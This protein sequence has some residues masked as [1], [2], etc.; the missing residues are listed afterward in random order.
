MLHRRR[1]SDRLPLLLVVTLSSALIAWLGFGVRGATIAAATD[2]P[3]AARLEPFVDSGLL[4]APRDID[5]WSS[6]VRALAARALV[7]HHDAERADVDDHVQPL[8]S[9]LGEAQSVRVAWERASSIP[10]FDGEV[11]GGTPHGDWCIWRKDGTRAFAGRFHHGEPE[12][13][14]TWW[15]EGGAVQAWG[16]FASGFLQGPWRE[17]H[18]DGT[19][20]VS[21]DYEAGLLEG[22]ALEFWPD[23]RPKTEGS[24]DKGRRD[25]EWV[26]WHESGHLRASGAYVD[27]LRNG[28]WLEWH[29]SG[30]P[31]LQASYELGRPN[32]PWREWYSNGQLKAQG[33]FVDGK[34][35]GAWSFFELDGGVDPRTGKYARGIPV[36]Q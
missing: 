4:A 28:A 10:L 24:H 2:S 21:W 33:P 5:A 32:G 15:H 13:R 16:A 20:A 29:E 25:G 1:G 23:G 19:L 22:P 9:E 12:G 11:Q 6:L 36:P 26:T 8:P 18:A 34:R 14:W 17:Y 30:A 3:S 35:E 31:L 7:E 27:G